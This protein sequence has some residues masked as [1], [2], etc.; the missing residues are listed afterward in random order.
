MSA[1]RDIHVGTP[2][3]D[4]PLEET[5]TIHFHDFENL[6]TVKDELVE[7]PK[8]MCAGNEWSL[9]LYPG[10]NE[11]AAEGM[12]SVFLYNESPEEI[13][14]WYEISVIKN[15]GRVYDDES[16]DDNDDE[17]NTFGHADNNKNNWG[18]DNFISRKEILKKSNNILKKGTLT[19]A[20]RIKPNVKHYC[21]SVKPQPELTLSE[22]ISKLFGDIDSADVAFTVGK[23]MFH[24]HK[25]ILKAQAPELLELTEQFST[26]NPMVIK[27]VDPEIFEMMLGHVYGKRIR[28]CDWKK[29]SKQ[30]LVASGKYGLT[31]LKTE[32][33]AWHVKNLNLTIDNAVDELLYA[34]GTHCLNLKKAVIEFIVKNCDEVLESASYSK[35]HES[36]QLTK[37]VIKELSKSNSNKK[38]KLD[39]LSP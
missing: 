28:A 38:R 19:F 6:T 39:K 3:A 24:A 13:D 16:N 2:A 34:D 26:D 29:H 25:L 22:N 4:F 21:L 17:E 30:I 37:E 1:T 8:F 14:A 32:A 27:D 12:V 35:L 33:E 11:E 36:P 7:S 15:N 23:S 9:C 20:I 31:T 18:W 5:V 10:G